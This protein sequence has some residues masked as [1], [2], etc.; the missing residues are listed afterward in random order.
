MDE[1]FEAAK[2]KALKIGAKEMVVKDCRK[3]FVDICYRAVQCNAVFE[4]RY[5]LGTSLARPVIAKAMCSYASETGCE[6]VAHG[7]T[8]RFLLLSLSPVPIGYLCSS[9]FLHGRDS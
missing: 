5:L 7:C 1:D 8:V 2:A 9:A 3:E 4:D 6:F